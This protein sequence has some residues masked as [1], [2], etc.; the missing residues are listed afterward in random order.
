MAKEFSRTQRVADQLQRELA[1]LI[2]LE[3]KDPRLGMVTVSAVEVSR[4]L[5]VA[6]IYVSFLGMDDQEQIDESLSVLKKAS[7]FLRSQVAR[8]MKLRFTPQ[9]RFHFDNSLRRG[10]FLSSLIEE[11]VSQERKKDESEE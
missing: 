8:S 6:N 3:I 7:G 9:L 4:D 10:A 5:A 1:Q 11:A 2:Q